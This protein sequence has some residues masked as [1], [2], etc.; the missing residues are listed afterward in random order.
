MER[1][2]ERGKE[3]EWVRRGADQNK[4]IIMKYKDVPSSSSYNCLVTVDQ[5]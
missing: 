2:G 5:K 3:R 4:R 1:I